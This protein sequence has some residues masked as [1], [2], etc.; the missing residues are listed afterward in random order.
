MVG[1]EA[2]RARAADRRRNRRIGTGLFAIF[3]ACIV[4]AVP[5]PAGAQRS[6]KTYRIGYLTAASERA[7]R[8]RLTALRQ[9]LRAL[10]YVEGKNIVIDERFAS[11]RAGRVPALAADLVGRKPDVIVI[12]GTAATRATK[13][14]AG[15]IPIVFRVV[16]DPV[17]AGFVERLAR[18]GGTMT[19]LSDNHSVL[20]PKRGELLREVMPS[21]RRV[22]VFWHHDASHTAT[23]L[24]IPQGLAPRMGVT[25]L[26]VEFAGPA[27]LDGADEAFRTAPPDALDV[28]G[29]ALIAAHR[30]RLA[31]FAIARRLPAI[32]T[33]ESSVGA[34]FLLSYGV[35]FLDINR[36]AA[37]YVDRIL[38]GANP[39]DLPVELPTRFYLAVN[40]K[41]ARKLGIAV[42]PSILLR[43]DR[44]IE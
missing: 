4:L 2:S 20:V 14:V 1:R 24:N 34:G 13:A 21:V 16:A 3:A 23:Q 19:G 28:L 12:H 33:A 36:R 9:G 10:G 40:L 5:D 43:A 39:A 41:T 6:G 15:S 32:S 8:P 37:T 7:F 35:D 31:D 22:A 26:P 42:P 44:V 27:D 30:K 25:L 38:K 29:Y 18:P 17:S 11:G